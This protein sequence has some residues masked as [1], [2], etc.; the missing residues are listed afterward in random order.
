MNQPIDPR[1]TQFLNEWSQDD[2]DARARLLPLLYEELRWRAATKAL[3]GD[4]NGALE[5]S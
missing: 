2:K 5:S 4:T 3:A 1:A